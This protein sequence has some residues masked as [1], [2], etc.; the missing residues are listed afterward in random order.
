MSDRKRW[1]SSRI[2]MVVTVAG[3][4]RYLSDGVH[5]FQ[6]SSWDGA[7][8]RALE[9][10]GDKEQQYENDAGETVEWKLHSVVTLDELPDDLDGSEVYA[11][12]LD[13]D[14][15]D[16]PREDPRASRPRQTI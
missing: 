5:L 14:V 10:G 11:E 12:S 13:L 4:P 9:I 2:R 7:F 1:Y 6:S 3:E 8:D 15:A 16:N